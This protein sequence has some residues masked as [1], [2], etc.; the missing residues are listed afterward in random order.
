M[1]WS[2]GNLACWKLIDSCRDYSLLVDIK[3]YVNVLVELNVAFGSRMETSQRA[4]PKRH[5]ERLRKLTTY[6]LKSVI[7]SSVVALVK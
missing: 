2:Y 5:R 7:K 6:E 1:Q 4:E 3:Q